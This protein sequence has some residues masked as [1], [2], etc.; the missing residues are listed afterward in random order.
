M[1][2]KY[3]GTIYDRHDD[4]IFPI[5]NFPFKEVIGCSHAPTAYDTK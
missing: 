1:A 3:N 5:V 2:N 4:F